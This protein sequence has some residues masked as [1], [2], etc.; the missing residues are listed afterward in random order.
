MELHLVF[1]CHTV[2]YDRAANRTGASYC[3]FLA[4]VREGSFSA[5]ARS[6]GS[7][8]PT[9]GR[10]IETLEKQLGSKLFARSHRG[11][12]PTAAARELIPY[13][14][15]MA[16]AAAALHRVSSGQVGEETGTVR[17]TAGEHVGLEVLPPMLFCLLA[18]S[19]RHCARAL[20]LQSE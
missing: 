12:L 11:L 13:A 10:Q 9:V 14:E 16:S 6:M 5:A 1:I 17:L 7:T 4:V 2:M 3:T 19:S 8:Q 20:A 15:A 18:R